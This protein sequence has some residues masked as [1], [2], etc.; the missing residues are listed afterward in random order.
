MRAIYLALLITACNGD[1]DE[2]TDSGIP[3]TTTAGTTGGTTTGTTAGTT[4]GT[5]TATTTGTT[6]GSTSTIQLTVTGAS[7]VCGDY[8]YTAPP[9]GLAAMVNGP[10]VL[11]MHESF[12]TGCCPEF[13]VTAVADPAAE[14]I[15]ATY[16]IVQDPCD[17]L[18]AL[19]ASYR[20][21]GVP[22]GTWTLHAVGDQTQVVMP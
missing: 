22:S 14:T 19:D 13:E 21:G 5:T 20:L 1:K 3:T 12:D 6:T 8:T 7:A 11:V 9:G 18:C 17:C 10:D 4:T 16:N 2:A 15:T